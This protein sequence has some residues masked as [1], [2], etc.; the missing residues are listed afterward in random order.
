MLVDPSSQHVFNTW[1]TG[2]L[3]TEF[4]WGNL[5]E[6]DHLEDIRVDGRILKCSRVRYLEYNK[7]IYLYMHLVDVSVIMNHQCMVTNH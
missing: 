7:F 4:W 3:H 6:R 2:E 5:R 1:G